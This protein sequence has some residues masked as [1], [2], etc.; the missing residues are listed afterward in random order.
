MLR[1]GLLQEHLLSAGVS[2]PLLNQRLYSACSN[3]VPGFTFTSREIMQTNREQRSGT[4]QTPRKQERAQ[5]PESTC[6]APAAHVPPADFWGRPKG[7][8]NPPGGKKYTYP[9]PMYICSLKIHISPAL[10]TTYTLPRS[11]TST[12]V[13]KERT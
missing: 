4:T 2:E 6:S 10:K 7:P 9:L 11:E 5:R 13:S 12:L 3:T 1:T 8:S